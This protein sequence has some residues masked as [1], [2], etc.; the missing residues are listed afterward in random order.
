MDISLNI[1]LSFNILNMY[2]GDIDAGKRI[3]DFFLGPSFHLMKCINYIAKE[4]KKANNVN[5]N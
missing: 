4:D 3:S 2:L 1:S 5:S